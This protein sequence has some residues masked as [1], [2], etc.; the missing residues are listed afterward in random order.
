M[1]PT[2]KERPAARHALPPSPT[3]RLLYS[4][5][6]GVIVGPPHILRSGVTFLGRDS[7]ADG[8]PSLQTDGR[9]SR[10]HASLHVDPTS[11]AVRILDQGSMNGTFV[12]GRQVGERQ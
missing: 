5:D 1:I 10:R 11:G 4:G 3:L 7:P 9:L 8:A 12:A 6:A 2:I